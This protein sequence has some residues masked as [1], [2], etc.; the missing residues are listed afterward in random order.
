MY[1]R[2]YIFIPVIKTSK[3]RQV[4]EKKVTEERSHAW[5]LWELGESYLLIWMIF[6]K[7][8]RHQQIPWALAHWAAAAALLIQGTSVRD[9]AVS[10]KIH[11]QQKTKQKKP[12]SSQALGN[13]KGLGNT[14]NL[15]CKK[16][17]YIQ[18]IRRVQSCGRKGEPI[19]STQGR[20]VRVLSEGMPFPVWTQVAQKDLSTSQKARW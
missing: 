18:V 2:L 17:S 14:A 20:G 4:L 13:R 3:G 7:M 6:A 9:C 5:I 15:G 10:G 8:K 12:K 19:L 16:M 11:C 1:G